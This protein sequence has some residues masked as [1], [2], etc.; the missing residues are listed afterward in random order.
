[1]AA[2]MERTQLKARRSHGTGSLFTRTDSGGRE[3]W[4]GKWRAGETQVKR[5]LGPKR[6]AGSRDGL[7]R[8]QAE[9]EL[10][11][12]MAETPGL[13]AP[14]GE[15]LSLEQLGAR[16]IRA[17]HDRGRKT[18]SIR[19]VESAVRVHFAPFFGDRAAATITEQDVEDFVRLLRGRGL[20]P[21][22]IRNHLGVL[23]ALFNFGIR[24]RLGVHRNPVGGVDLPQVDDCEDIRFLDPD[25][26]RALAGAAV[27]G[28]YRD[29]DEALFLTAA[30]TGLRLGELRALR[31][32]DVDWRAGKVRVRRNYVQGEYTTPKSRRGRSVPLA[33]EVAGVLD[34][35][36][37]AAA[38]DQ[39]EPDPDDLVFAHPLT[40]GPLGDRAILRRYRRALKAVGL[41]ETLRFHDLRHTFGTRMAAAGVPMRTLQEW[42]GH[43]NMTTTE[44]YADY[45]P[46]THEAALVAS[47]F[48]R[49]E[50]FVTPEARSPS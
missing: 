29:L 35:L 24:K 38:C 31:W 7:T 48:R 45:A 1:M 2:A 32:R 33:D 11:R 13:A 39:P 15:R 40:G 3:T 42:L 46:S 49:A 37:R 47:A 20:E 10:R 16:Y 12:V 41:D 9:A 36:A 27:P 17:M 4:Y 8:T 5:R 19:G 30:M 18:S 34:R 44:R 22:T 14:R 50:G 28:A 26:V 21:K 43:A 6:I 25:D 23:G